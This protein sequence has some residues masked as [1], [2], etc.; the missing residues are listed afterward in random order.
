MKVLLDMN[1]PFKYAAMLTQRGIET[2]CWPDVGAPNAKDEEIMTYAR[3][4]NFIVLT[5]DLDF[6]TLL[7][8]THD[9]KPSVVQVRA[10]VLHA[11]RV[12]DLVTSALLKNKDEL[13]DGA[14]ISIDL[15]RARLR[16]LPI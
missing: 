8:I 10:S 15:K 3:E 12:V 2:L 16:L 7:S 9:L 14:I 1:I 4:N 5:C 11:E 6:S 13:E